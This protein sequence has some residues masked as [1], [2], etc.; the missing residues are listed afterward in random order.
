M[1]HLASVVC[2][3]PNAKAKR[4]NIPIEVQVRDFLP[5]VPV[6]V[7]Q[8]SEDEPRGCFSGRSRGTVEVT[9]NL[10]DRIHASTATEPGRPLGVKVQL[11]NFRASGGRLSKVVMR[12]R[13]GLNLFIAT[14]PFCVPNTNR[15]MI[16]IA[17]DRARALDPNVEHV[18]HGETE[19]LMWCVHVRWGNVPD[20][21]RLHRHRHR[22]GIMF[23]QSA[24]LSCYCRILTLPRYSALTSRMTELKTVPAQSHFSAITTPYYMRMLTLQLEVMYGDRPMFVTA[25]PI[26][27]EGMYQPLPEDDEAGQQIFR[28]LMTARD[29]RVSERTEQGETVLAALRDRRSEQSTASENTR[30]R[31]LV[32][33]L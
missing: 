17:T 20:F 22:M 8:I 27:Y 9:M 2:T 15:N 21:G 26:P 23:L 3:G 30:P 24:I 25:E 28:D 14:T 33:S 1:Q 10:Y 16:T 18:T 32:S 19:Q 6:S 7:T 31:V 5:P 13:L 4:D 11:H 12:L 29:E